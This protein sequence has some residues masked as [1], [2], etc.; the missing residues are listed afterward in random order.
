LA[1]TLLEAEASHSEHGIKKKK[2]K[3]LKKREKQ[4]KEWFRSLLLDKKSR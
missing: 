1:G 2:G 3:K 4:K